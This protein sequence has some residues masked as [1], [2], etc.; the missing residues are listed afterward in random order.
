MWVTAAGWGWVGDV[1]SLSLENRTIAPTPPIAKTAVAAADA[2]PT[3]ER[4]VFRDIAS[5]SGRG[6]GPN[7]YFPLRICLSRRRK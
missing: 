7:W 6:G 4:V 1:A 3:L 5:S 2:M